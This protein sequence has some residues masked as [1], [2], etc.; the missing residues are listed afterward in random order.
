MLAVRR[1][2]VPTFVAGFLALAV[3]VSLVWASNA[4]SINPRS[5]G[6]GY[7]NTAPGP[8]GGYRLI[9]SDG[10]VFVYG[11]ST[12]LGGMGGRALA[13]PIIGAASVNGGYYE[14]A[15]DG[16]VF[17]FGAAK[18]FG[19]TGAIALNKPIVAMAPTPDGKGYWLVASDGGVFAYG[20]AAFH[21][22]SASNGLLSPTVGVVT[23]SV[24]GYDLAQADGSVQ[25]Y[26]DAHFFGSAAGVTTHSVVAIIP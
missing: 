15:S 25:S 17:S 24:G 19:S 2:P 7:G 12:Y 18:F 6:Y 5:V 3:A 11:T 14:V 10:G 1:N 23:T 4:K 26:G 8:D 21:G 16:G 9:A 20:D 13:K 22:S